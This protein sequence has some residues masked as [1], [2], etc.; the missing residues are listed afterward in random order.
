MG[1]E[2]DPVR[3]A[4]VH[5]LREVVRERVAS[6]GKADVRKRIADVIIYFTV[7]NYEFCRLYILRGRVRT[8]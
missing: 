3:S 2:N 5:S 4:A 7:M 8:L 6:G 1:W